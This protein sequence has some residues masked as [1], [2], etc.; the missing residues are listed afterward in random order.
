[1]TAAIAPDG[2]VTAKLLPF[3]TGALTVSAQ[4]Y[5]GI[6]PYVWIGNWAAVLL[7]LAAC[8][9]A[10]LSGQRKRKQAR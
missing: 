2:R 3:V 5:T 7:A 4:G 1:M 10:A 8:L 9:S 6:T